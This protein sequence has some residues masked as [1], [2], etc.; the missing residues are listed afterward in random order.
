MYE[1]Y[2]GV[3]TDTRWKDIVW[4]TEEYYGPFDTYQQAKQA[5]VSG[6]FN[7]KLDICTHRLFIREI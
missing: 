7:Q 5:W 4:G 2:G 1:V 6:M 3:W